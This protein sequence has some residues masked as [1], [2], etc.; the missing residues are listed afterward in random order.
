MLRAA[1]ATL[2]LPAARAYS[3]STMYC[4]ESTGGEVGQLNFGCPDEWPET[5][6]QVG[7]GTALCKCPEAS[8]LGMGCVIDNIDEV[9]PSYSSGRCSNVLVRVTSTTPIAEVED[10]A[11][12]LQGASISSNTAVTETVYCQEMVDNDGWAPYTRAGSGDRDV[13]FQQGSDMGWWE[14]TKCTPW[15]WGGKT[16]VSAEDRCYDNDRYFGETCSDSLNC[17]GADS[18]YDEYAT[19]CLEDK[20]VMYAQ[21][22]AADRQQCECNWFDWWIWFACASTTCDGHACVLSTGDGNY[23]CDLATEQGGPI[24][25]FR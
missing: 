14:W 20:C 25:W 16:W 13:D 18:S 23:Y 4:R 8:V 2:L 9:A 15:G 10:A 21:A 19:S 5:P 6:C 7:S 1:A 3:T 11:G 12:E 17:K 22:A 24:E